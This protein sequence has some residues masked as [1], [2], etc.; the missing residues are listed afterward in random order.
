M[1]CVPGVRKSKGILPATP[2][3]SSWPELRVESGRYLR[4]EEAD[5]RR[6]YIRILSSGEDCSR[7]RTER[8]TIQRAKKPAA[9]KHSGPPA[10]RL[11]IYESVQAQDG[12]D[13]LL[14]VIGS[15]NGV[16][17]NFRMQ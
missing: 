2:A 16:V 12:L 9:R 10:R 5:R 7:R 17:A 13:A 1:M 4:R 3:K 14:H 11:N 15:D 6:A 8:N